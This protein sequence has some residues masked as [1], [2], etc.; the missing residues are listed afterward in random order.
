MQSGKPSVSV[1]IP[2]LNQPEMLDTCLASLEAQSLDRGL[3]EIFVVDNGSATLPEDV[4]AR[5]PGVHLF[6]EHQP[7]PGPARNLG[8]SQASAAVSGLNLMVSGFILEMLVQRARF[9]LQPRFTGGA[10]DRGQVFHG[11]HAVGEMTDV[12]HPGKGR[13]PE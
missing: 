7:G 2:H 4:V 11:I 12:A 3:F 9:D 5:H 1:I 6:C 10:L 8:I 13:C